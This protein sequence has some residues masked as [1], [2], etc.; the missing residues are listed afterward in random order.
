MRATS[1]VQEN[2]RVKLTVEVDESE[3]S[4]AL[5]SVVKSL[6]QQ[7]RIPGFRP[8]KVPR[9]VLEARMGGAGA[10]RSEALRE[11]LPE[12][13]AQAVVETETDP[14]AAPEIDITAGEEE[15]P[16]TFEAVVEVRPNVSVAGYAGLTAT[17]PSPVLTDA[18]VEAQIDRLR[19]NDGELVEVE[20]PIL[21]GDF[22]T[23]DLVGVD[24][25]GEQVASADDYLYEVGSGNII[26]ELDDV[27]GG[28]KA[29]AELEATGAPEGSDSITF[30]VTVTKVQEKQLP[31]A[32]DEWAAEASEFATLAELRADLSD[33]ISRIKVV[34]AQMA[35]REAAL[36]SLVDLVDD[37][38]VPDALIDAE[39]NE[40][41]HDLSHRLEAQ[42]LSIEQ[43][44]SA[45]GQTGDEL[46]EALRV[47]AQRAVKVDLGLRAVALAEAMEV[48]DAELEEEFAK[49]AEQY[50]TTPESIREQLDQAGRTP[51]VKAAQLKS[52]A[53]A[54]LVENVTVVDEDGAAV[55]RS[56]LE[57]NMAEDEEAIT[58]AEA[59]AEEEE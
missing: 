33:R 42:K 17:I 11:A 27:L 2:N 28:A 59:A 3:I 41:I 18:D 21:S 8:G 9:K 4:S 54:G 30:S 36:S 14:I 23:L 24:D 25:A 19:E 12:F 31:E 46:V 32:T 47:D 35:L 13:Y 43:F 58:A 44:L 40:R 55:D 56:L 7:V 34:Q 15:G 26:A 5:D 16:V 51:E 50:G 22:V 53:A 20:R 45:T 49:M 57:T 37:A 6:G 39:V 29:G 10:L 1:E 48:S 52:K 38:E